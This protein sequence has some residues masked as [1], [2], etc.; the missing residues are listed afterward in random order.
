MTEVATQPGTDLAQ[1]DAIAAEV[2]AAQDTEWDDDLLSTPILKV[3]QAL[4]REVKDGEAEEGEF[5]DTGVNEGIGDVVDVVVAYY[6]KG[7]FASD[8]DGQAYTA[9]GSTIP[10]HWEPLVG[11][12]FVGTPFSEYPEAEETFKAAVNAGDREWGGG[13]LVSTTH[14]FTV[15]A[16]VENADGEVEHHPVRLSLKRID[17]PAAR[18]LSGLLRMQLRNRPTWDKVVRLSTKSKDFGRNS[19]YIINPTSIKFVRDTTPEERSFAAQLAL[20]AKN[21][22]VQSNE[23]SLDDKPSAASND[24]DG[25]I[26]V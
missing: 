26:P 4:T 18:K 11:Q 7:R 8:K 9:F 15:V 12:E 20:A 13:P 19:A 22:R 14:N 3:G 21:G 17:V 23:E 6:N 24:D 1:L 2:A 10:S 5:I 25:S 16:L